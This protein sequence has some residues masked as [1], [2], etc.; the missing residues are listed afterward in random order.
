MLKQIAEYLKAETRFNGED[1]SIEYQR[2][3]AQGNTFWAHLC[4]A[5]EAK[6]YIAQNMQDDR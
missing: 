1:Y 2:T 4:P 5:D 6:R 3:D